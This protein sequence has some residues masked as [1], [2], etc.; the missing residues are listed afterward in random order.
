MS[1]NDT[2]AKLRIIKVANKLFAAKGFKGTSVRE[3][4]AKAKINVSMINYY[5][6]SKDNLLHIILE[7]RTLLFFQKTSVVLDSDLPFFE[8]IRE[9]TYSVYDMRLEYPDFTFLLLT[10]MVETSQNLNEKSKIREANP[11]RV[12][13]EKLL[14]QEKAKGTIH[15]ISIFSF[16]LSFFSF[17]DY[18]FLAAPIA[19]RYQNLSKDEYTKLLHE[20]REHV[21]DSIIRMIKK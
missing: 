10:E 11:M 7:E 1:N 8:L 6:Q 2:N 9:L 19:R 17:V 18:P 21:A 3:I 12:K 15:P 16:M 14:E 4:A 20:H 5:F 13:L